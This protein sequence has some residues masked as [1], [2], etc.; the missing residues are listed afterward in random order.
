MHSQSEYSDEEIELQYN[1]RIGRPDYDAAVVPEW[2]ERSAKAR[3][4]L[5]SQLDVV[6]G[7]GPKQKLDIFLAAADGGPTLVYF[8]GGYWQ[9]GDKSIYS[10]LAKPF[11]DHGVN[12]IIV[13]Y[14]LC[15]DVSITKISEEAREALAW[16]WQNQN[17]LDIDASKLTV[18]G[19]SAGG[20][21]T[22]MLMGTNWSEFDSALPMDLVK[23][24]IPV[25][26]LND[27]APLRRTSLNNA[28]CMDAAEAEAESPMNHPPVT[29]A[30]QLVVCGGR[31]TEEF[32]RQADIYV[33]AFGNE[34]R[35]ME[36]YSVPNCDHFDELNALAD[37][38]SAFFRK[39]IALI[40]STVS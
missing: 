4:T 25:S 3:Q 28:V 5:T 17:D 13:G 26:P 16:I 33:Q 34:S 21:I 36:R 32:H 15:P 40:Q 38:D 14:D 12:V 30:P 8:H 39:S 18:M 20:H 29:N 9:R 2:L 37:T 22:A 27:L 6:Y 23:A 10:F 7:Q 31:E 1:L 35:P 19:H 11:V 24:G